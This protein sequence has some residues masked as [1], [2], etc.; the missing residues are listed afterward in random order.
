MTKGD[1]NLHGN[2]T[3]PAARTLRLSV[4]GIMVI[5]LAIPDVNGELLLT[6]PGKDSR[7]TEDA[8]HFSGTSISGE[9]IVLSNPSRIGT[10]L[11]EIVGV[12]KD[13]RQY[14]EIHSNIDSCRFGGIIKSPTSSA[15]ENSLPV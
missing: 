14:V 3:A 13:R 7:T 12:V 1:D 6:D 9:K 11:Q 15:Y 2:D 8:D 10:D 5:V 4:I